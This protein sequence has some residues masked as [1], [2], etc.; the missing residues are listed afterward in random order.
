MNILLP[1]YLLEEASCVEKQ[2]FCLVLE[3]TWVGYDMEH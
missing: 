2:A 1:S 3:L